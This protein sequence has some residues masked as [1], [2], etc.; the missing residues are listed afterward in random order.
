MLFPFNRT[1]TIE[2]TALILTTF[3]NYNTIEEEFHVEKIISSFSSTSYPAQCK[4]QNIRE[5]LTHVK[6]DIPEGWRLLIADER[7]KSDLPNASTHMTLAGKQDRSQAILVDVMPFTNP[8]FQATNSVPVIHPSLNRMVR[9]LQKDGDTVLEAKIYRNHN[10][11]GTLILYTTG[12]KIHFEY[13][14]SSHT[15]IVSMRYFA[16]QDTDKHGEVF[17]TL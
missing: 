4:C 5:L 3:G 11:N 2:L 14:I 17:W 16:K 9:D 10:G 12:E 8:Y 6:Y 13:Q 1:C 7:A 15:L